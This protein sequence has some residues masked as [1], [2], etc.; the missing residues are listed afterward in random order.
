MVNAMNPKQRAAAAALELVKS[1]MLLGLGTGS[2]ADC[3][4]ELLG[5]AL[6]NGSLSGIRA[7]PTSVQTERRCRQL[8]IPLCA[9]SAGN[10]PD[11]TIDGADEID[12]QLNL[13][14]G[15]GGALLREKIVAQN[16]KRL[17]IIAD[18][19]KMVTRLG[20]KCSL[21]V[22]VIAFAHECHKDFFKALGAHPVLRAATSGEPYQTDNHNYIYDCHFEKPFDPPTV[23]A[24]LSGR[25]GVVECG[26]FLDMAESAFV[27]SDSDVRILRAK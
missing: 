22:E 26:L 9:L 2:T 8:D 11:L 16:S 27:A 20:E 25:A 3:L 14:K 12:A 10:L 17:V 24:A 21:P 1:D 23:L 18:S 5:G 6:K 4:I 19:A 13:I 7:I 15:L